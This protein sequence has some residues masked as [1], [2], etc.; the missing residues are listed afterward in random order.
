M[1]TL[2]V[3]LGLIAISGDLTYTLWFHVREGASIGARG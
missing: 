3:I 2:L 1:Q